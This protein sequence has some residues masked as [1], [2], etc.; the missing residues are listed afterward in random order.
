MGIKSDWVFQPYTK[1]VAKQVAAEACLQ[2]IGEGMKA[3]DYLM[4]YRQCF[5]RSMLTRA[6]NPD[7]LLTFLQPS[8]SSK[9]G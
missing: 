3:I 1:G 7:F 2:A 9:P 4:N 8:K 6:V 5:S